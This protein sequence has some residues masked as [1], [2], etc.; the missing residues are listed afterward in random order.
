MPDSDPSIPRKGGRPPR[1]AAERLAAHVI[2]C[3]G[4]LF[5]LR[6]YAGVSI[7]AVAAE[8]GV[9]KNTIYRR[10]ATKTELFQAVVDDK[11]RTL[12]PAPEGIAAGDM[13]GGLRSLAILL[14]EAAL[15]PETTALQRLIIAEAER[16][17]EI[18]AICLDRAYRTAAATAR[19]V[20]AQSAPKGTTEAELDFAAEQFV[21]AIAYGPNLRA[22]MGERSLNSAADIATYAERALALFL[23]GWRSGKP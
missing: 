22:L 1:D 20:L 2:A 4:R 13:T 19:T 23:T 10:Y 12:L 14:V 9:G 3:A 17:P 16:F 21:A 18:A 7:E 5:M 11:I 6:G 8:A 15:H